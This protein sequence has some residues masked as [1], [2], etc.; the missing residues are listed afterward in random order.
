MRVNQK[1]PEVV[2][3][4]TRKCMHD[5]RLFAP[6][7]IGC[8]SSQEF[9]TVRNS[10][11][12]GYE[13]YPFNVVIG[14]HVRCGCGGIQGSIRAMPARR[15]FILVQHC[16]KSLGKQKLNQIWKPNLITLL[17][18]VKVELCKVEAFHYLSFLLWRHSDGGDCGC[19]VSVVGLTFGLI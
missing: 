7:Y 9:V 10:W 6:K 3:S 15:Y 4:F 14:S 17:P 5:F 13:K 1:F 8:S 16:L 2:A 12:A 18:P 19:L 11:Q